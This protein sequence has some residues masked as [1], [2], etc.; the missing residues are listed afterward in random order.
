MS[1]DLQV[2]VVAEGRHLI[3]ECSRCG[4]VGV[5]SW[6]GDAQDVAAVAQK[7]LAT[8]HNSPAVNRI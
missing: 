8:V 1:E 6:K 7:H 2:H 5:T 4:P 3:S